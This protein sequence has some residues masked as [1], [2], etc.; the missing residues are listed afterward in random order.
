MVRLKFGGKKLYSSDYVADSEIL[1]K[2]FAKTMIAALF[3]A[4]L[5]PFTILKDDSGNTLMSFSEIS[6]PDFSM[7]DLPKIS[8]AKTT[9]PLDEDLSGKDIFYKW[10]DSDGNIQFT[11]EPP[12]DGIQYTLKGFDPDTNV[13]QAVNV[14]PKESATDESTPTQ[15]KSG[16]PEEIGNPYSQDSIKKLFEDTKNIEKLLKQRLQDQTSQINQ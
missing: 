3:I 7:P 15:E 4:M 9:A 1:M 14:P 6:L 16:D 11:S 8:D 12:P 2:L 13:I 10:Y 5:L